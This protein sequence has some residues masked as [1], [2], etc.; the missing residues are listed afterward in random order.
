MYK[1]YGK[2]LYYYD[3]NS[4]YPYVALPDIECSRVHYFKD[5]YRN[6]LFDLF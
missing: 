1:A 5:K 6:A 3:V 4:L 2:N